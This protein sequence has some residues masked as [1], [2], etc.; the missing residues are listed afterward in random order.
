[1]VALAAMLVVPSRADAQLT[2]GVGLGWHDDAD[3]GIAV[4]GVAPTPSIHENVSVGGDVSYFFPDDDFDDE[5]V[6]YLEINANMFYSFREPEL[7][8]T[9][10]VLG[11]LNIARTSVDGDLPGEGSDTDVG[12][13][14]GGGIA[15]GSEDGGIQPV[16]G[17]KL[18]LGGGEGFVLF[19]G[20]G[21]PVG[22]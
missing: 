6:D 17:A 15:F 5:D 14:A 8:F 18:E 3:L 1:M 7:T 2:L 21:F 11:G 22:G 19:G 4:Y 9:P 16:V 12:L 20:I 10:F 13:N